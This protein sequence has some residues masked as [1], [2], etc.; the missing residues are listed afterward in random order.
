[1]A[2]FPL[3]RLSAAAVNARALQPDQGAGLCVVT[4]ND[5][6][7]RLPYR[8]VARDEMKHM[9]EHEQLRKVPVVFFANKK[10]LPVAMPPLEIAQVGWGGG[11]GGRRACKYVTSNSRPAA[12]WVSRCHGSAWGLRLRAVSWTNK[13]LLA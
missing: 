9:L 11:G 8:V 1:M 2:K 12:L 4:R 3:V 7:A 5:L 6:T 13:A 10:D